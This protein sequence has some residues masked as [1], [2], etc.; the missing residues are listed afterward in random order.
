MWCSRALNEEPLMRHTDSIR[1]T[2]GDI[3]R[4]LDQPISRINYIIE[5]RGI[6][7]IARVGV[8]RLFTEQS[9]QMIA[10]ELAKLEAKRSKAAVAT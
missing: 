7:P 4:L 5:S 3:S 10:A 2:P 6:E 1:Y 8:I 9:R